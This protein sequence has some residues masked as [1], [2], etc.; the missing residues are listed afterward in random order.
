VDDVDVGRLWGAFQVRRHGRVV[1]EGAA[2]RSDVATG[3]P[4][5]LGTRFQAGSISKQFVAASMLLLREREALTLADRVSQWWPAAPPAWASMT[6]SHLL[7]HTSGLPHW[8]GIPG[9]DV[10]QPPAPDEILERATVVP[11]ESPPGARWS[12]SGV[13]YLLAAAIIRAASGQAYGPFVTDNVF[14]PLGMTSTTS[15]VAPEPRRAANGH[16]DGRPVPLVA[17]LTALPGT[18]D[19]WTTVGDLLL[20]ADAVHDGELMSER[21]WRGMRRPRVAIEDPTDRHALWASAYGYGTY[22][23]TI[24]GR[25]AFFHPGDNPGFRSL[26]AWL[27]QTDVTIAVLSNDESVV[28]D[29]IAVRLAGAAAGEDGMRGS[30]RWQT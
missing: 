18:G 3:E 26:L 22:V 29:D 17:G 15:G 28:L 30:A 11:L 4:C 23:G 19:V 2:G 7:E 10:S 8:G 27:P 16:R 12:Y 25:P 21:S 6:V 1:T 13:G 9:L 14:R 24:A 20:Y 5:T